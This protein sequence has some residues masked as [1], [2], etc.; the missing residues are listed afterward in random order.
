MQQ[1]YHN[2]VST[3]SARFGSHQAARDYAMLNNYLV[4]LPSYLYHRFKVSFKRIEEIKNN[5]ELLMLL[6]HKMKK[7]KMKEEREEREKE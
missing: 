2:N 6:V 4:N 3:A 5:S 1:S 7:M